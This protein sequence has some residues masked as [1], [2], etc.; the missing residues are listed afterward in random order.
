VR[1]FAAILPGSSSQYA[2]HSIAL[3]IFRPP[4]PATT[5]RPCLNDRAHPLGH[6]HRLT[7]KASA[8]LGFE[9]GIRQ[10]MA[11][12]SQYIV[13]NKRKPCA[14]PSIKKPPD[15]SPIAIAQYLKGT[16]GMLPVSKIKR[17]QAPA[18]MITRPKT[19]IT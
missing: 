12:R 5:G 17:P 9:P 14:E 15:I 16:R 19:A 10:N 7:Q 2:D 8:K 18:T 1:S 3:G 6:R 13:T 4:L 11:R